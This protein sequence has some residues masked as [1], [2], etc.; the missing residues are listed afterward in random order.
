MHSLPEEGRGCV[1]LSASPPFVEENFPSVG[2][3]TFQGRRGDVPPLERW[4]SFTGA[5][6]SDCPFPSQIRGGSGI[7]RVGTSWCALSQFIFAALPRASILQ[8]AQVT[9][10]SGCADWDGWAG[11]ALIVVQKP[12]FSGR[13]LSLAF[14]LPSKEF[15]PLAMHIG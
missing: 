13:T 15:V 8:I 5:N 10:D 11:E 9:L 14:S 3:Q 12:S 2:T 1:L 6:S 7:N 4:C